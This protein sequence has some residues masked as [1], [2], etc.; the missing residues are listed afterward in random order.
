M[1]TFVWSKQFETGIQSVDEQ[2]LKLVDLINHFSDLV[3]KG[4]SDD[5]ALDAILGELG[6]Y[7]GFHFAEEEALMEERGLDRRHVEHHQT[8]HS[9]F[10]DQLSDMWDKRDSPAHS[11]EV[12]CDFLSSWLASHILEEDQLMARQMALIAGGA[13]PQSAYQ[14]CDSSG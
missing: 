7:A 8:Q 2:H 10:V 12:L 13:S 3:G 11:A 1:R 14:L 6:E 4:K 9:Q 5:A